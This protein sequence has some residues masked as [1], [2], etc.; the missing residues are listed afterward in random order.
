M[1]IKAKFEEV[2]ETIKQKVE[3][4]KD[5][6]KEALKITGHVILNV[7][8]WVLAAWAM[9]N[10][11]QKQ[12]TI[13][14]LSDNYNSLSDKFNSLTSTHLYTEQQ[15]RDC[16]DAIEYFQNKEIENLRHTKRLASDA[17]RHGS[18]EGGKTMKSLKR[19]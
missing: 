6:P 2:K 10:S 3:W 7:A 12:S 8:P 13:D 18:S 11:A 1:E 17:L 16:Q 15:L 9:D 19:N 4:V 5:N 14:L